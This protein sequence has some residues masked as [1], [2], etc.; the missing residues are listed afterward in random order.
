MGWRIVVV[1]SRS[2]L[3]LKN[4]YLVIRRDTVKRVHL[5]EISVLLIENTG[6][7]VTVSLLEALWT[8][9]IAVIL[10]DRKRNPGAQIIP[11]Y[12]SHDCSAKLEIQ[13]NW[14]REFID[15]VWA[16]IIK[17]K[18]LGQS[19][20]LSLY[21]H[22]DAQELLLNYIE[23]VVPGDISNR[24][25]HAA[26][27]YF[28]SVFGNSFSR[29]LEC[30]VNYALNYGYGII[31]ATVSREVVANGYLTQLGIFHSNVFNFFN[32]PCDLME[33]IR[34]FMDK[35]VIEMDLSNYDDL[36]PEMKLEII[37][38]LNMDVRIMNTKQ[39]LLNA[40]SIYVK[41]VLDAIEN[42][43][44]SLIKFIEYEF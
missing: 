44:L 11:Y 3:E 34:P 35:K 13:L 6:S 1:S 12:G 18:I 14:N 36:N 4:N 19:R 17:R 21:C 16:E 41:S 33:P 7:A 30:S 8:R 26:K 24:E 10:C 22:Q 40:I 25:G 28:N 9:K 5:D 31:M 2:K 32:L 38:V 20:V 27:V 23:E 29:S 39:T 37:S 15:A 43:D 42:R